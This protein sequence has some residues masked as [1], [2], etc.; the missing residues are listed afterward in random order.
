MHITCEIVLHIQLNIA[1]SA[2]EAPWKGGD[3]SGADCVETASS[4]RFTIDISYQD[5]YFEKFLSLT[6]DAK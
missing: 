6:A 2:A 1:G 3:T 4:L 5:R